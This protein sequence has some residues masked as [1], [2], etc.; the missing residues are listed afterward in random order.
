[1]TPEKLCKKHVKISAKVMREIKRFTRRQR[2]RQ[3]KLLLDMAPQRPMYKGW[4]D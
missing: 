3:G 2:R 1:M 4:S